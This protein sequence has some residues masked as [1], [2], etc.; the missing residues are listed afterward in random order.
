MLQNTTNRPKSFIY[1][2]LDFLKE[3]QSLFIRAFQLNE[4]ETYY[5]LKNMNIKEII[6]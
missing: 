1:Y 3:K 2:C 4:R 6:G 5:N